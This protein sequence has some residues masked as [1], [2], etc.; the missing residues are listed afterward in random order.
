MKTFV[1][2]IL[3]FCLY[4]ISLRIICSSVFY[5]WTLSIYMSPSEWETEFH[6]YIKQVVSHVLKFRSLR[7]KTKDNYLVLYRVGLIYCIFCCDCLMMP[8]WNCYIFIQNLITTVLQCKLSSAWGQW[9]WGM[10]TVWRCSR[11][12]IASQS[13]QTKYPC[14]NPCPSKCTQ[15][16]CRTKAN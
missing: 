7:D 13:S 12:P 3:L 9:W 2:L 4:S 15:H 6:N 8:S 10:A 16:G 14:A 5:S 1:L 11:C